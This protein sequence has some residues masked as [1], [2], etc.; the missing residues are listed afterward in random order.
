MFPRKAGSLQGTY[1]EH[2]LALRLSLT[3]SFGALG[4]VKIGTV[5]SVNILKNFRKQ[6]SGNKSAFAREK[7]LQIDY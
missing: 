7:F 3:V 2:M 1:Q 6:H 4:I 5:L